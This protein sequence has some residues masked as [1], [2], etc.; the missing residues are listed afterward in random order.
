MKRLLQGH[1]G[2][3][4]EAIAVGL[5]RRLEDH[6]RE[7]LSSIR[8]WTDAAADTMN[9]GIGS[10]ALTVGENIFFRSNVYN[11]KQIAGDFVVAHEVSHV[12]Q[13]RRYANFSD[14]AQYPIIS[15]NQDLEIEADRSALAFICGQRTCAL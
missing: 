9:V 3:S 5:R 1:G 8:I 2:S 12:L 4:G 10:C 13:K 15:S 7:D 11:S 14:R 6:F